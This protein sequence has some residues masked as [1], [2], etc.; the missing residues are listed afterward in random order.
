MDKYD[1]SFNTAIGSNAG[2][3]VFSA[4]NVTCIGVNIAGVNV[5]HTTWIGNVY[6]VTTQSGTTAPAIVSDDDQ[7]GTVASCERFKKDISNIE[8]ISEAILSLRP[9]TFH[10]KTDKREHTAIWF[11]CR[12]GRKGEFGAGFAR[13]RRQT[14]QFGMTP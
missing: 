6:G 2:A 5:S 1:G 11:D 3:S 10:Y 8:K 14:T 13:Q 4:N 12:R 7:L 9:V